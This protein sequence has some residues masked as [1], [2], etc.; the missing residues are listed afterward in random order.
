[1]DTGAH[2]KRGRLCPVPRGNHA[3]VTTASLPLESRAC[4]TH[5]AGLADGGGLEIGLKP[6]LGRTGPEPAQQHTVLLLS[7]AHGKPQTGAS[8]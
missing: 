3:H 5:R 7:P 1:M 2:T 6:G 4:E 8:A